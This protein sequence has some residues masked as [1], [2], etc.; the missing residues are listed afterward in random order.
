MQLYFYTEEVL[1]QFY[2]VISVIFTCNILWFLITFPS[3]YFYGKH[4]MYV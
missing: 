1:A 2:V 3:I 4:G